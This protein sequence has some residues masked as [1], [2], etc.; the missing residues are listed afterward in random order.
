MTDVSE[1]RAAFLK[2]LDKKRMYLAD[3]KIPELK[4]RF[5]EFRSVHSTL[6][7]I[8]VQSDSIAA[9]PYKS[10]IGVTS[11]KM[12]ENDPM[13]ELKKREDFSMRLSKY[14][15]L[16]E[17]I[18]SF[19]AFSVD[20]LKPERIRILKAVIWFVDW[21]N[22]SASS[23]SP[24][25]QAMAEIMA[26]VRSNSAINAFT[27]KNYQ[28]CFD[29]LHLIASDIDEILDEFN[30]FFGEAY[31]GEIR[32]YIAENMS[33]PVTFQ[34]VKT[35]FPTAFPGRLFLSELIEEMLNEDY[36]PNAQV[37]RQSTLQKLAV[38]DEEAQIEQED[39]YNRNLLLDGLRALG[40]VYSTL[41]KI[42]IK[43]EHNHEVHQNRRKSFADMV[44]EFLMTLFGQK[45]AADLYV[46]KIR[47]DGEFKTGTIE[48]GPFLKELDR[49][50]QILRLYAA[51]ETDSKLGD[52]SN[53]HLLEH[54]GE[55]IYDMQR[56]TRLLTALD[57]FFKT[58]VKFSHNNIKGMKPEISTIKI[59]LS[60]AMLKKEYYLAGQKLSE[61]TPTPAED[62]PS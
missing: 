33:E 47:Q 30:S 21:N 42:I 52:I 48:H 58:T 49:Q 26:K 29:S 56:Y 13:P 1:W 38:S 62:A 15:N 37:L 39:Q 53:A 20:M 36:S 17:Y 14:D 10:M 51:D 9:D 55:S 41:N 16:L 44:K 35:R 4:V 60:K 2:A 8:L 5:A 11:L 31:K 59:A 3:I 22:L 50:A 19:Y 27:L 7:A 45:R 24:N 32:S 18:F 23:S 12:P 54:L 61:Q 40:S 6:Y 46:Y 43:I 34:A 25:T 28:A 57:E